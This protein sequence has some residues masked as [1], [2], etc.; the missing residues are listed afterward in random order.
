M[1]ARYTKITSSKGEKKNQK[2]LYISAFSY[3]AYNITHQIA[4]IALLLGMLLVIQWTLNIGSSDINKIDRHSAQQKSFKFYHKYALL[5]WAL[6]YRRNI[7]CSIVNRSWLTVFE[8]QKNP[9]P[10]QK[11]RTLNIVGLEIANLAEQKQGY[12][13]N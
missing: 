4:I 5:L 1:A 8:S 12:Y 2:L 10:I 3:N 13:L 6:D 9:G 7:D 11:R